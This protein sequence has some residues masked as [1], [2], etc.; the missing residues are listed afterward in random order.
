MNIWTTAL[1]V[2]S[3]LILGFMASQAAPIPPTPT[4]IPE[5]GVPVDQTPLADPNYVD[6]LTERYAYPFTSLEETER[7][8]RNETWWSV[9]HWP[10]ILQIG[11]VDYQT[12]A[13]YRRIVRI[14]ND[15]LT[16]AC[17]SGRI[18]AYQLYDGAVICQ[19]FFAAYYGLDPIPVNGGKGG[20]LFRIPSGKQ[21]V[22]ALPDYMPKLLL[23]QGAYSSGENRPVWPNW[24]WGRIVFIG[25]AET[26]LDPGCKKIAQSP[27]R[28]YLSVDDFSLADMKPYGEV[29]YQTFLGPITATVQVEALPPEIQ[30]ILRKG[31]IVLIRHMWGLLDRESQRIHWSYPECAHLI[32]RGPGV[33]AKGIATIEP[34]RVAYSGPFDPRKAY[35]TALPNRPSSA[36]QAAEFH[37]EEISAN[38][39]PTT[40]S[41]TPVGRPPS[42]I[43]GVVMGMALLGMA[44]IVA[45]VG[46]YA[47]I[48]GKM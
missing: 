36:A 39:T 26:I 21:F 37:L 44:A 6:S 33:M 11:A 27:N 32:V 45:G 9:D 16:G 22:I 8:Y 34:D 35:A 17:D 18:F 13:S 2:L 25:T 47:A 1:L 14:S 24:T 28:E 31:H 41:G 23:A 5:L 46:I 43:G 19:R 38:E 48:R 3:P 7:F 20:Y 40:P 30:E 4:P 15:V 10:W 29:V 42:K 12:A